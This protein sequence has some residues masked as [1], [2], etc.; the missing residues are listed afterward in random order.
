MLAFCML[1]VSDPIPPQIHHPYRINTQCLLVFCTSR[2]CRQFPSLINCSTIDWF[3]A[4]PAEAL[5]SVSRRFLEGMDLGDITLRVKVADLC[6]TM[7]TSVE[8]M[9]ERYYQE[10]RR[11]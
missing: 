9:A 10:M 8:R 4:W 11:R 7:H 2:R 1:S 6:V 5:A 3:N